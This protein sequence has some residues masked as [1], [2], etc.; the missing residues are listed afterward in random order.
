MKYI[1]L[2][3][4][5]TDYKNNLVNEKVNVS[6]DYSHIHITLDYNNEYLTFLIIEYMT[7]SFSGTGLSYSLDKT[8]KKW[9]ALK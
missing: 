8:M 9:E 6:Y 2:Y 4:S 7:L 3:E 1:K 5:H